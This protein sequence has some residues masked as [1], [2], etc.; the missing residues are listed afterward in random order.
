[1]DPS[2]SFSKDRPWTDSV[3]VV[4]IVFKVMAALA[5]SV[6]VIVVVFTDVVGSVVVVVAVGSSSVVGAS[7]DGGGVVT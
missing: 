3:V 7:V 5:D 4:A 1:M 2:C 6:S